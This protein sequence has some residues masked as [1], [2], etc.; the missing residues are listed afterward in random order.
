MSEV[1]IKTQLGLKSLSLISMGLSM[2]DDRQGPSGHESSPKL[3]KQLEA[4]L[5]RVW[6]VLPT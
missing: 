1:S 5:S 4:V 6:G 2:S 3:P